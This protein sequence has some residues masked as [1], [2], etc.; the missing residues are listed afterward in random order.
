MPYIAA[1]LH[2]QNV[3]LIWEKLAWLKKTTSVNLHRHTQHSRVWA[4]ISHRNI[5]QQS[6][7]HCTLYDGLHWNTQQPMQQRSPREKIVGHYSNLLQKSWSELARSIPS[8]WRPSGMGGWP[9]IWK[10]RQHIPRAGVRQ[11]AA[12]FIVFK[13]RSSSGGRGSGGLS[14]GKFLKF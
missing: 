9:V 7:V 2:V 3:G 10:D 6:L 8:Y 4:V 1:N 11:L 12:L 5:P 13:G 14:P